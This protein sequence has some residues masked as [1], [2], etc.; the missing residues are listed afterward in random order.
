M[1][2]KTLL[3]LTACFCILTQVIL[4]QTTADSTVQ[5][6]A[7]K[8]N[9]LLQQAYKDKDAEA[10]KKTVSEFAARYNKLGKADKSDYRNFLMGC[11]YN[12]SCIYALLDNKISALDY[13]DSAVN[14]G[15]VNY[16][17]LQEDTD[18]DKIRDEPRFKRISAA[19]R[20][21]SDYQYILAKAEKFNPNDH[22][23]IPA[24]TYQS[25]KDPNLVALRKKFNLDSVAGKGDDASKAINLLHWVHNTVHHDGQH[26]SGVQ[27][28]NANE[29]ISVATTKKVG[30][31]CGELAT[32]LN[33]CYL[34]MGFKSRKVYCF[35]KD[36]LGNDFDSHVI[37]VV[38]LP[39]KS[40]WVW[41]DPTNDAYV[42]DENKNMLSIQEVRER[43]ITGKPLLVN[44]DAN[45]N[46]QSTI[47]KT[48]YLDGYMVK[49][50]YRF[51]S[52]LK[53]EYDY[54][55]RGANR[56]ISYVHLLPLD[57]FKQAPQQSHVED[58]KTQMTYDQYR[59]N[60]ADLFWQVTP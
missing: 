52:P 33:E 5:A 21:V 46:H 23:K 26:E 19:M 2:L 16:G 25:A 9:K 10:G 12:Q 44:A 4:A 55:T 27:F 39:S 18:L 1:N 22:R 34:A 45:W 54:E 11:Y 41:V 49:N 3:L 15:Y 43:L 7:I 36:S 20:E 47:T 59:T 13:L 8:Q 32:T 17:H 60:N 38:Y 56:N 57:Y 30:V 29:I 58:K 51:Y 14:K 24:F 35:P 31:S 42:M 40:K 50:L 53:S 37:N 6:Y 28:I 48:F